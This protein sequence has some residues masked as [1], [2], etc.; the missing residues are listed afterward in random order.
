M[1]LNNTAAVGHCHFKLVTI[2]V[3]SFPTRGQMTKGLHDQPANG[4]DFFVAK[5]GPES[6]VEVF[7]RCQRAN[8]PCGD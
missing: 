4:I 8:S 6:F 2:N 5:V 7:N 1:N 3:D